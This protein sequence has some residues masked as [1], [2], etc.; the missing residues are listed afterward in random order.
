MI[1]VRGEGCTMSRE[2]MSVRLYQ[3]VLGRLEEHSE[4]GIFLELERMKE[5]LLREEGSKKEKK[6]RK[7]LSKLTETASDQRQQEIQETVV[8]K[9]LYLWLLDVV[10]FLED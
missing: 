3:E 10:E 4:L 7:C 6:F 5:P 8:N 1:R 9:D 2:E